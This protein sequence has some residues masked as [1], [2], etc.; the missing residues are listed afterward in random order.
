MSNSI[1]DVR[2]T[3]GADKVIVDKAIDASG[4]LAVLARAQGEDNVLRNYL[5]SFDS[6]G[7]LAGDPIELTFEESIIPTNFV[8]GTDGN[9]FFGKNLLSGM[10]AGHQIDF[11]DSRGNMLFVISDSRVVGNLYQTGDMIYTDGN[12]DGTDSKNSAKL[13]PIDTVSPNFGDSIDIS[14][15]TSSGGALYAGSD[16]FY[17]ISADGIYSVNLDSQDTKELILW[18][19][20]DT[21]LNAGTYNIFAAAVISSDNIFLFSSKS[22]VTDASAPITVSLLAREG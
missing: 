16:G 8:I 4:K 22:S 5:Y 9:M 19:D 3:I 10:S 18:K 21:D 7:K 20:M 11:L 6:A 1:K 14:E 15:V 2:D 13:L 12:I 17:L